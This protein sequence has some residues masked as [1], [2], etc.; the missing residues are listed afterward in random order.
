MMRCVNLRDVHGGLSRA[1]PHEVKLLS[2]NKFC[3]V[4]EQT[5]LHDE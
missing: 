4:C 5:E 1:L 3:E 2:T